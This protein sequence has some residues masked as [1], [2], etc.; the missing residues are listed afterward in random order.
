MERIAVASQPAR[1]EIM[2]NP[3]PNTSIYRCPTL[4]PKEGGCPIYRESRKLAGIANPE[5]N[6]E[7]PPSTTT[8]INSK[9][10]NHLKIRKP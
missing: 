1:D 5:K 3:K 6:G 10:K 2:K 9:N 4:A 7:C 8:H